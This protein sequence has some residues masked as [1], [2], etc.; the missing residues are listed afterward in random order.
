MRSVSAMR[1]IHRSD[2]IL[3]GHPEKCAVYPFT[4]T[5]VDVESQPPS[6]A[7]IPPYAYLCRPAIHP[8][9]FV[10]I[11]DNTYVAKLTPTAIPQLRRATILRQMLRFRRARRL[12][13]VVFGAILA[14]ELAIV[15][16]SYQN[17]KSERLA[18]Y[19]ELARV[20]T[21]V[22]LSN[23]Q[24]R[25]LHADDRL[26]LILAADARIIGASAIDS[27]GRIFATRGGTPALQPTS[28]E[29]FQTGFF[30]ENRHYDIYFARGK[31]GRRQRRS[32]AHG[33]DPYMASTRCF[34]VKYFRLGAAD[35]RR[36]RRRP[37]FLCRLQ[38]DKTFGRHP[39]KP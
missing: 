34:P 15:Y 14:I 7:T 27:F 32:V 23:R 31:N 4:G 39:S 33:R 21:S 13:L 29:A 10:S 9:A 19:L 37:V 17:A 30:D 25:E 38:S 5:A 3:T 8:K 35:L 12:I 1:R 28:A 16:P 24:N 11:A 36:R 20:A 18:N 6:R 22:A 26:A 2:L